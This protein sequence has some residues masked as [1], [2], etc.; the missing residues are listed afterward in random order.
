MGGAIIAGLTQAHAKGMVVIGGT[1]PPFHGFFR[2]PAK[3]AQRDAVNR[4]IRTSRVFDGFV[5][6]DKAV[7]DPA[8]PESFLPA[9]DSGDGLHPNDA[10]D[11]AM[12]NAI[13]LRL[14]RQQV[15]PSASQPAHRH[16]PVSGLLALEPDRGGEPRP[17]PTA[18]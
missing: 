12:A 10:G 4:F 7:R 16:R 11:Q 17:R 1:V 15:H 18:T 5:D 9:F 2:D 6:F 8:N 3:D 14:F 13:D